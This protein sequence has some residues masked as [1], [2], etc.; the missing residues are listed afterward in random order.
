MPVWSN[1]PACSVA[2]LSLFFILLATGCSALFVGYGEP[3]THKSTKGTVYLK[4]IIDRS[5][6]VDHPAT[7]D[8]ATLLTAIQGLMAEDMTDSSANMPVDGGKPM[9][10]FSDEDA[11]FLAP[12]LADGLS[13]AKPNQLVGFTVSSSAGSGAEPA[14]G[15]IYWYHDSL[16]ITVSTTGGRRLLG[17]RPRMAARVERA[18]AYT[19]NWTPGTQTAVINLRHLVGNTPHGTSV[20]LQQLRLQ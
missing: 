1:V 14:A 9:R 15:I 13:R 4:P 5:F 8:K 7:I 20:H 11:E 17:F 19:T 3:V 6:I 2:G 12:L 16:H 18:P 10:V